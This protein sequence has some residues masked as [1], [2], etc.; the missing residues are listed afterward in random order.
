VLN[1]ANL[2]RAE[3]WLYFRRMNSAGIY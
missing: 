1:F 3:K 2:R